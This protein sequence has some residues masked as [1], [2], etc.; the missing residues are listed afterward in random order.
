MRTRYEKGSKLKGQKYAVGERVK[1]ADEMPSWMSHFRAGEE[2]D[3]L[4]SYGQSCGGDS[5]DSYGVEFDDGSS[6]AWYD[7][8]QLTP[9]KKGIVQR[10]RDMF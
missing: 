2:V 4:Y 3:V 10:I 1:I 9:V 5:A 8:S 7:E 6:C